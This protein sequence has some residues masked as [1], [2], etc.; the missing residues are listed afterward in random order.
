MA[1]YVHATGP[2]AILSSGSL[3]PTGLIADEDAEDIDVLLEGFV[4]GV[5]GVF[6]LMTNLCTDEL[7]ALSPTVI[8]V[9]EHAELVGIPQHSVPDAVT[10]SFR[11][12]F[13]PT[14]DTPGALAPHCLHAV[15]ECEEETFSLPLAKAATRLLRL[16]SDSAHGAPTALSPSDLRGAT[17]DEEELVHRLKKKRTKLPNPEQ[18]APFVNDEVNNCNGYGSLL[19]RA[20]HLSQAQEAYGL[21]DTAIVSPDTMKKRRPTSVLQLQRPHCGPSLMPYSQL[22]EG[23]S[24]VAYD[25]SCASCVDSACVPVLFGAPDDFL[26]FVKA[27]ER[28]KNFTPKNH[29]IGCLS[30]HKEPVPD[31]QDE[32]A[33]TLVKN[34]VHIG[35]YGIVVRKRGV[36]VPVPHGPHCNVGPRDSLVLPIFLC[37]IASLLHTAMSHVLEAHRAFTTNGFVIIEDTKEVDVLLEDLQVVHEVFSLTANLAVGGSCALTLTA[38]KVAERADLTQVLRHL[39]YGAVRV[40]RRAIDPTDDAPKGEE[41]PHLLLTKAD[42]F[43]PETLLPT[44]PLRF[45]HQQ[46]SVAP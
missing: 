45:C 37:A 14:D 36:L 17:E 43:F 35:H 4:P 32:Q 41:D 29:A 16:T 15:K 2:A 46:A 13:D 11:P 23:E 30:K 26:L 28:Y 40:Y 7:C 27:A 19:V 5:D 10:V 34:I 25:D 20:R 44:H 24:L 42:A 3:A 22:L 9:T 39:F 18:S 6:N 8:K 38:I 1:A 21:L 33:P 12:T 31:N